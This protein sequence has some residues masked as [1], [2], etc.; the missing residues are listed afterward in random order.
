MSGDPRDKLAAVPLPLALALKGSSSMSASYVVVPESPG[1]AGDG[2]TDDTRALQALLRTIAPGATVDFGDR[3]Y[4]VS[5]TLDGTALDSVKL[6]GQATLRARADTDFQFILDISG[7][8]GI[9]INGLT[10][11]ANKSGRASAAGKLSCLNA[12]A[13]RRCSL[14]RC[15]F[16]N[17]LGIHGRAG[18][19]SIAVSASGQARDLRV[20]QCNFLDCGESATVRPSDGIFVRGLNCTVTGCYAENVTDHAFALEGCDNSRIVDCTGLNCTSIAGIS[21]D[22]SVDVR[23]NL[24]SGI[25]GTCSYF[26]SF[27]GIV[28]AYTF[29]TG[30]LVD[31]VIENIDVR[32]ADGARGG[33]AGMYLHGQLDGVR[34]SNAV[35]DAGAS[36]GV[37]AHGIVIDGAIDLEIVGSSIRSDGVGTCIRLVN[38]ST[39][40]RIQGNRLANGA[41]GIYADGTS[42]FVELSNTFAN[43]HRTIGLAG[44]ASRA[45][46]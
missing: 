32:A 40:V 11:D 23:G 13:T 7:A 16:K 29:G 1:I 9:E 43:C 46:R 2:R 35:I 6:L 18:T 26:G 14:I 19:S 30:R 25:R 45:S 41:F 27:G 28:G 42:R 8:A 31:C 22:T 12:N 5:S 4:V 24:I 38:A 17:S 15:T 3:S 33:G 36:T 39:G 20:E 21:N 34:V 44:R 10:F 37:M